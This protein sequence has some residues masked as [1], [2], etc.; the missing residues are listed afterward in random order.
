MIDGIINNIGIPIPQSLHE[1]TLQNFTSVI[2]LNLRP[3]L[4]VAQ[5][6]T[7]E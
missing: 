1:I 5:I 6:F 2:D 3:A 4:E 7:P